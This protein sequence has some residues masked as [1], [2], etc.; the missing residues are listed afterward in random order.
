MHWASRYLSTLPRAGKHIHKLSLLS[1]A[2]HV[3]LHWLRTLSACHHA[4][5]HCVLNCARWVLVVLEFSS[6]ALLNVHMAPMPGGGVGR[7][8]G[9]CQMSLFEAVPF[10]LEEQSRTFV[11]RAGAVKTSSQFSARKREKSEA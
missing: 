4:K 1:T 10:Q 8:R 11:S 9:V 5:L 7:R 6:F 2:H 3:S